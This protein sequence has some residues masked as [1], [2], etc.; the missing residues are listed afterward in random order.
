M[1]DRGLAAA[2]IVSRAATKAAAESEWDAGPERIIIGKDVLELLST[3]MYVDPMT[4]Y[5]ECV[6]NAA[7]AIDEARSA[8]LLSAKQAGEVDI[9]LDP[10]ARSIKIRDNRTGLQSNAFVSRMCNL[11]GS[12]K[13]GSASHGFRG[14]FPS[15]V[16][17]AAS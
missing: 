9:F 11:G 4:V 2:A 5:R 13:R 3:S 16:G 6:Q 15:S 8:K 12:T 14:A 10:V 7:N 1:N 17:I